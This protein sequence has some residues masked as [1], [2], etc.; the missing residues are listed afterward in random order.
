[1]TIK[2]KYGFIYNEVRFG[3]HKRVLY[4]LPFAGKNNM[5]FG[6]KKL[7]P[8]MLNGILTYRCRRVHLTANRV[9]ELTKEVDW[10]VIVCEDKLH[11]PF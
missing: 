4:R 2:F 10:E 5:H 1:M 3:W 8:F 6:L 11:L 7:E 9:K